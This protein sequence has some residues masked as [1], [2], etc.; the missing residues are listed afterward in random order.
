MFRAISNFFKLIFRTALLLLLVAV[1][2]FV[3]EYFGYVPEPAWKARHFGIET[4]TA[5]TDYNG[6]GVDDYTDFLKGAKADARRHPK[7]VNA[8]Y[9]GGYPPESE[10]V[11]TDVIWRAFRQAGY[12]LKAMIDADIAARPWAYGINTPDPNIDFRRVRNQLI[13][14]QTYAQSLTTDI[15]DLAQWQ[16]GDI[17]VFGDSDHIGI[18]SDYRAKDGTAFLI[19]NG[20]HNPDREEN[21]L[22]NDVVTG[23]YRFDATQISA[24]ILRTWKD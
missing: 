15:T 1:G 6:N 3:A 14:F 9:E 23:H 18:I 7:Y 16:P 2:L 19:H 22:D 4:L 20:G 12:D 10:G 13:F 5:A 24:D 17:V 11:C 8:Y 21:A